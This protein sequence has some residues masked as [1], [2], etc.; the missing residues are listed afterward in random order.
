MIE[1]LIVPV[2]NRYD[3]L[4]RM[5]NSVDYP[6]NHLLILDNGASVDR[7]D[8]EPLQLN[9]YFDQVTYLPLPANLGVAGSWN[10][11]IKLFPHDPKW[12]FASNDIVFAPGDL[13]Q[14]AQ[15]RTNA[16][17]LTAAQPQWQAFAIGEMVVG[18]VGL[19]DECLHPAY[20]EDNDYERR[21]KYQGMAI[22]V[23]PLGLTHDNSSTLKADSGF[24][25]RNE[26]TFKANR[27]YFDMKVADEDYTEGGWSL[28][29]RRANEWLDN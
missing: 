15:A 16:L 2:L 9:D 1:N 8:A 28:D 20:F 23:L 18:Y 11:G 24:G 25:Y 26:V 12:V 14:L 7:E 5:V 4:Q 13:E 3:L 10:L 17:T 6:V 21:V 19:F 22:D 27:D 29:I